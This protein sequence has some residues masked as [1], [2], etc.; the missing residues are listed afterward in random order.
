MS[1][2]IAVSLFSGAGGLDIGVDAA[3]YRTV[4]A[5]ESDPHCVATLRK[6][7]PDKTVLESDIKKLDAAQVMVSL[8]VRSGSVALLHGGPP[9]QPFSQI[10][11]KGGLDDP[12]GRLVFEMVR[13][14]KALRPSA[15]LME[16]VPK[17]LDTLAGNGTLLKDLL[18]QEFH[19][20][21]YSMHTE[22]L[23][24]GHFGIAQN[25]KRAF[26]VCVERGQGY[27]FPRPPLRLSVPTVGEAIG[28]LPPAVRPQRE[29]LMANHI[30]ITPARDRERISFVPEGL[31]LSKVAN[32]PPNIVQRL[33]PKDS[34]KFR[35]LDRGKPSLTLRCGEALYHPTEDRYLTPR[36]SA[37]IQGF[38]DDHIFLGPIRRRSGNVSNLDQHRQV[39]NAVPPPLAQSIAETL[40]P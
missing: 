36:E 34:T 5:I 11:L 33:T 39:A 17:F 19:A 22:V 3:G 16:Q 15:I 13:F 38:P 14:A 21:G 32:A 18:A 30:D 28:D 4:C 24:A 27:R 29:P 40:C 1:K 20:A 23:N 25:R 10:G 9:C 2:P 12:R 8:G 35:R 6:N 7:A 37:R 26:I 31:W